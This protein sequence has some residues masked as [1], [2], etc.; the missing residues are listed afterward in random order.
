MMCGVRFDHGEKIFVLLLLEVSHT[1][2]VQLS[3]CPIGA[4]PSA[5]FA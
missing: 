4:F 5:N 2:L 3:G 1:A